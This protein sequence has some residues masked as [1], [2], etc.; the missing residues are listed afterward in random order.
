[1]LGRGAAHYRVGRQATAL[2]G[3]PVPSET[4]AFMVGSA[5]RSKSEI[6]AVSSLLRDAFEPVSPTQVP[7]SSRGLRKPPGAAVFPASDA[8]PTPRTALQREGRPEVIFRGT[9]HGRGRRPHTRGRPCPP[10]TRVAARRCA[11][12][13]QLTGYRVKESRDLKCGIDAEWSARRAWPAPLHISPSAVAC[14]ADTDGHLMTSLRAVRTPRPTSAPTD[15][16][17]AIAAIGTSRG[18]LRRAAA[19]APRPQSARP[20]RAGCRRRGWGTP[21]RPSSEGQGRSRRRRC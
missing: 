20:G 5:K 17:T 12:Y 3:P 7:E 1:V 21:A 19:A 2:S 13:Q 8:N 11:A 9:A 4:R 16:V 6:R 15:G 18:R 14:A 10:R